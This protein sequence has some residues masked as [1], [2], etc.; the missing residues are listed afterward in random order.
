MIKLKF[1]ISGIMIVAY[2]MF[3]FTNTEL[4]SFPVSRE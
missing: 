2:T 3:I 4:V 1:Q